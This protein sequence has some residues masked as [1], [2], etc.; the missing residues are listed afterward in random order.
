MKNEIVNK[1]QLEKLFKDSK[2]LTEVKR[3]ALNHKD[4]A[5]PN[6]DG[7]NYMSMMWARGV[8]E[9]LRARGFKIEKKEE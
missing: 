9:V 3:A 1:M 2:F 6:N 5:V 7:E 4:F 8:V